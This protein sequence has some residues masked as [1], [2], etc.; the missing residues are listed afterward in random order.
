MRRVLML[1]FYKLSAKIYAEN[2]LCILLLRPVAN[3]GRFHIFKNKFIHISQVRLMLK[4]H[5]CHLVMG[6]GG[7]ISH[8]QSCRFL[9]HV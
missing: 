6:E 5:T 4:K 8:F 2:N 9:L 3:V 7:D 1:V